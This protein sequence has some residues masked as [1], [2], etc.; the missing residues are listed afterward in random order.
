MCLALL[1]LLAGPVRADM[2]FLLDGAP[3]GFC[4]GG[5]DCGAADTVKVVVSVGIQPLEDV[6]GAHFQVHV[7]LGVK[8]IAGDTAVALPRDF[9]EANWTYLLQTTGRAG[10]FVLAGELVIERDRGFELGAWQLEMN[11]NRDSVV[12]GRCSMTREEAWDGGQRYRYLGC[13]RIPIEENE[14]VVTPDAGEVTRASVLL[15][16][17]VSCP[18]CIA[19]DTVYVNAVIGRTGTIT[20]MQIVQTNNRGERLSE[21]VLNA[22]RKSLSLWQFKPAETHGEAVSDV[23]ELK[24]LVGGQE[25]ER[26]PTSS[27][28]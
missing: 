5:F 1:A 6:V 11:A 24:V 18:E 22:A 26:R 16:P 27:R 3:Y 15:A 13:W 2:Q 14:P 21:P 4:A 25:H 10:R 7:P 9:Q 20:D 12:W 17:S 19:R 8:L 23:L 28:R